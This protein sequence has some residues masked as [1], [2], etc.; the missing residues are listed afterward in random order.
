MKGGTLTHNHPS[1]SPFSAAD[2]QLFTKHGLGEIRATGSE[3]TYTLS[4][5]IDPSKHKEIFTAVD[6]AYEQVVS[7]TYEYLKE[8]RKKGEVFNY[9]EEGRRY[10]QDLYNRRL[11]ELLDKYGLKYGRFKTNA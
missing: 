7:E 11:K 9:A 5:S 1:G 4:G 2:V 6:D 10:D 3:Y 8:R